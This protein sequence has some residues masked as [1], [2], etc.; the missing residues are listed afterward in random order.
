MAGPEYDTADPDD[1]YNDEYYDSC[2]EDHVEEFLQAEDG[3]GEGDADPLA[4]GPWRPVIRWKQLKI[5]DAILD[6]SSDGQIKPRNA[7]FRLGEPLATPGVSLLGTPYRTYTVE[8]EQG[9][10]RTYYVHDLVYHA[11]NGPLPEGYEVRHVPSHTQKARKHYS[12][13]LG[14]LMICPRTVSPLVVGL[15]AI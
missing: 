4:S 7:L 10:Y 12:N 5:G 11:F 2:D 8:V 14:C 6:V 15:R 9:S 13:R 1:S 3:D